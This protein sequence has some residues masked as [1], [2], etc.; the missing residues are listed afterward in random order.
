[1]YP[2]LVQR[3]V[4]L[5]RPARIAPQLALL[6]LFGLGSCSSGEPTAP[7]QPCSGQVEVRVTGGTQGEI[8]WTP[9]CGVSTI[10]VNPMP[11]IGVVQDAMWVISAEAGSL[12][13]PSV[14][15]GKRPAGAQETWPAQPVDPNWVYQVVLHAP[16]LA[17]V[18][19]AL[20]EP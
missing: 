1:M 20:W 16:G 13:G 17:I 18:G 4:F 11:G 2:A 6:F 15:Y 12:I 19:H 8:S 5:H 7:L 14:R 10:V 3:V 9:R